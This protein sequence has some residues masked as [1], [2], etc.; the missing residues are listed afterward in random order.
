MSV[1]NDHRFASA[2]A[3]HAHPAARLFWP[4]PLGTAD[5]RP[6]SRP[7]TLDE[8]SGR[9]W[10]NTVLSLNSAMPPPLSAPW[11]SRHPCIQHR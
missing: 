6:H 10:Q 3:V 2:A 1:L 7:A 8:G 9:M 11:L 5:P 4:T